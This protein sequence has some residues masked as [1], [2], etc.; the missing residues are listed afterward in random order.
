MWFC[1]VSLSEAYEQCIYAINCTGQDMP[2]DMLEAL[3]TADANNYTCSED[4]RPSEQ[5]LTSFIFLT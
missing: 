3:G 2:Y 5:V 1:V 4:L